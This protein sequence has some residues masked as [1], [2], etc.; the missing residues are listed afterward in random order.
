M[1][2]S[3]RERLASLSTETRFSAS[4][5]SGAQLEALEVPALTILGHPD[6]ERVGDWVALPGLTSGQ[7][8]RLSRLEPDFG[9]P[10]TRRHLPLADPHLSREPLSLAAAPGSGSL[11]I[12]RGDS[13]TPVRIYCC[14]RGAAGADGESLTNRFPVSPR[15]LRGGVVLELGRRVV[16]LLHRQPAVTPEVPR[17]GLIGDSSAM[18]RLRRDLQL[19]AR[20]ETPV[21]LRG[22]SGTGKE[23]AARALH[24]AGLRR[25]RPW[26]AVNMAAI[27][28]SL[29]AAELFGA[30]KGAYTG[31][32]RFQQG[33]FRAVDGG[34]LFL[35]EIGDTPAEVQPL[36]LR[37]LE[38]GEIQPVGSALA[39]KVDVRI[40][41]AT[42]ADL[43]AQIEAG[44][45][46]TPLLHR[47]A[48][49]EIRLPA[50][51]ERRS[52]IGRLLVHFL[53][54]ELQGLPGQLAVPVLPTG[55][56]VRLALHEWPGNVRQ[57]RNVAR[58]LA[59][60]A[61][62]EGES[63]LM[64][65]IEPLL[66][67]A[68]P[69]SSSLA[70]PSRAADGEIGGSGEADEIGDEALNPSPTGRWRP[71]YRRAEDIDEDELVAALR[72]KAFEPGPTARVLGVSRGTLYKMIEQSDRV[73]T[74][75]SL[76]RGEVESALERHRGDESAAAAALEVS[77]H[78]LKMRM[79]ALGLR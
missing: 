70:Q 77:A 49:W 72:S 63:S 3:D 58:R 42:D 36:L 39:Q 75:A 7:T 17:F 30:S 57:L 64:A 10:D 9:S 65:T 15:Q 18:L 52:D 50:L 78:G 1:G 61:A 25:N 27:P 54:Q 47:L 37:V 66:A 35:D 2:R 71:V 33:Y 6:V 23:L 51:R 22:A 19:A 40:L 74:A 26:V 14:E 41:A 12:R 69:P 24:D 55:L 5:V 32:D 62:A 8:A 34:T 79:A 56:V 28:P 73:R 20:L 46:R 11:E 59:V 67:R 60:A 45:F 43:E 68:A 38:N 13:R 53:R 76:G 4:G 31:A 29:A 16:L 44:D 21:L 48:S